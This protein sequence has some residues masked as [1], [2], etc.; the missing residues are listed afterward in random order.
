M[1]ST[2]APGLKPR[3]IASYTGRKLLAQPHS[4]ALI[5]QISFGN[6]EFGFSRNEFAGHIG[7][8]PVV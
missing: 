5:P 1:T 2:A 3:L 8:A 4:A 7:C 6:I